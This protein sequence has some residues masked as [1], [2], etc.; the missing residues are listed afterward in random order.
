MFLIK[1]K[2][3]FL[4]AAT[5]AA[6][7]IKDEE[8]SSLR[9]AKQYSFE[10]TKSSLTSALVEDISYWRTSKKCR[11]DYNKGATKMIFEKG[12]RRGSPGVVYKLHP[13]TTEEYTNKMVCAKREGKPSRLVKLLD[14]L[15]STDDFTHVG[16]EILDV[17]E[18]H[19]FVY[20]NDEELN[21]KTKKVLWASLDKKS[22]TW[23]P[24]KLEEFEFNTWLGNLKSHYV[25]NIFNYKNEVD[26]SVFDVEEYS[27]NEDASGAASKI[28]VNNKLHVDFAFEMYKDAHNKQYQ[29]ENEHE[30]RRKIF[31]KNL[32]LIQAHNLKNNSFSLGI[33]KFT[34]QTPEE[35]R[36]RKGL[37]RRKEGEVGNVPFPYTTSKIKEIAE[38]LP[39]QYDLRLFG[40]ISP[41]GD[42]EDCG[43]C[44]TFGTT[45]AVEGALARNNGGRLLR[46]ANQAL[47]DCAWGFGVAGCDGGSDTA[48]YHW[49]MEYGLPTV[50]EYGPY[51]NKDGFCQIENMTVTYPIKGF[52]DVTPFSVEALK[53]ALVNHGPLSV[54]IDATE[55]LQAYTGGVL[56]DPS[57]NPSALNH[58]VTLVGYGEQDGETYW[59]VRNSW[60]TNWGIDGYF[61]M[62]TRDNSC[63]ITTEPTYVVF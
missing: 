56:Y 21:K 49:M 63:G 20:E 31:E 14:I 45:A 16:K 9:W 23:I 34:D 30:M 15:P 22:Y 29:D 33:N 1:L 42:Q 61:H 27:C 53:V 60:G 52:T 3:L 17:G 39:K 58:E 48:A 41:V 59:I 5:A 62:S 8:L 25:W 4:L 47:V 51:K 44:W 7:S 11:I 6:K 10:A 36:R 55:L 28:D 37:M 26:S 2:I 38:T 24:V 40:V 50:E 46:L 32:R 54:S 12:S 13:E 43:S 18:V 19:K 35:M 57:C